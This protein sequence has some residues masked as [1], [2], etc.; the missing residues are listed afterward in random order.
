MDKKKNNK[1]KIDISIYIIIGV[2]VIVLLSILYR[3]FSYTQTWLECEKDITD[4]YHELVKYRF[5]ADD[6]IY[7]YFREEHLHNM[8]SETLE[9]NYNYFKEK[10]EE[11][12]DI[13][14]DNFNYTVERINDD[15]K[16]G[17]Y[18]VVSVYPSYFNSE[19]QDINNNTL[20]KD[21]E[22][23]YK[24]KDYTCKISRK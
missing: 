1:K 5:D 17:T 12:K 2:L 24:D 13:I 22:K 7:S 23:Y 18:V 21:V 14:N 15:V 16:V 4:D 9:Y 19:N 3:H 8:D 10:K 6:K 11:Y 20:F